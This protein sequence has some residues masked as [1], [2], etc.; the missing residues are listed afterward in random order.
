MIMMF[1]IGLVCMVLGTLNDLASGEMFTGD[2]VK[3]FVMLIGS[4]TLV[5]I[6]IRKGLAN[7]S[8]SRHTPNAATRPGK[9]CQPL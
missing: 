4:F 6:I 9:G 7:S 5:I 3:M 2:Y 8:S 1:C